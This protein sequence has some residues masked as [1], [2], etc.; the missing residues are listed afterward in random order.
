MSILMSYEYSVFLMVR[1]IFGDQEKN[2]K[3]VIIRHNKSLAK[4]ENNKENKYRNESS[5]WVIQLKASTR[6]NSLVKEKKL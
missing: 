3:N 5:Y 4:R 1:Q 6:S 2:M